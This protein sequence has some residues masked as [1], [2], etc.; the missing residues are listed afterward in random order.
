M[1][2][3]LRVSIFAITGALFLLVCSSRIV[4]TYKV[5]QSEAIFEGFL[6]T[7]FAGY[8]GFLLRTLQQQ[9]E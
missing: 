6:L 5:N 3:N 9:P 4:E 7:T 2:K 1:S 8:H